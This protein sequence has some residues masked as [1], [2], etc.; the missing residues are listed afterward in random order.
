MPSANGSTVTSHT[1]SPLPSTP[2]VASV[3]TM[4][5]PTTRPLAKIRICALASA[6]PWNAGLV[7]SVTSSLLNE[8]V[9]LEASRSGANG[10]SGAVLSE[11]TL[12]GSDS[13]VLAE[14]GA[15]AATA[16]FW[17]S[18]ILTAAVTKFRNP[19][20]P[21]GPAAFAAPTANVVRSASKRISKIVLSVPRTTS[22]KPTDT[23]LS[24]TWTAAPAITPAAA[25]AALRIGM[26]EA[27][28][29]FRSA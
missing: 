26:P 13:W 11:V 2:S 22:A 14:A 20:Y 25:W 4:A 7:S 16:S 19:R 17:L 5:C 24:N 10:A 18:K 21:K 12:S 1:P 8:P 29:S 23:P 28:K 6:T 3:P 27:A 15:G 9:S